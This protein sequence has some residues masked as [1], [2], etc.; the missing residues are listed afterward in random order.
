M[1]DVILSYNPYAEKTSLNIDGVERKESSRRIDTFITGKDMQTW[2]TP[3]V[4]SYRRWGGF[5]AELMDELND[6]EL[7]IL[8]RGTQDDYEK[9]KSAAVEQSKFAATNGYAPDA[10]SL[11]FKERYAPAVVR[12]NLLRYIPVWRGQVKLQISMNLL[13]ITE[14]EMKASETVATEALREIYSRLQK[15]LDSERNHV[16]HGTGVQK[17]VGER[18]ARDLEY[19]FRGDKIP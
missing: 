4:N 11:T 1:H 2:L 6:D 7:R 17:R 19:L 15:A 18:T 16:H 13:D 14:R 8:F 12:E 9:V 10:F 3:Y 5:L